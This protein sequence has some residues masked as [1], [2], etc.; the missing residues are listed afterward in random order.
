MG[1]RIQ[2]WPFEGRIR[3]LRAHVLVSLGRHGHGAWRRRLPLPACLS[4]NIPL[5]VLSRFRD[6]IR[7]GVSR[8]ERH[9]RESDNAS[10]T[11]DGGFAEAADPDEGAGSA[12]GAPGSL[13]LETSGGDGRCLHR[14]TP[15]NSSLV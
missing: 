7:H 2:E 6:A 9:A 12:E 15:S 3:P 5:G 13:P 14:H 8:D 10:V 11:A 4:Y 1:G